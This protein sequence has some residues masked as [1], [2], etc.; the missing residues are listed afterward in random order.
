[1]YKAFGC[2]GITFEPDTI[3]INMNVM[4]DLLCCGGCDLF[5]P[6]EFSIR[7]GIIRMWFD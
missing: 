2:I 1:M 4:R 5:N 7:N 3:Y 6:D